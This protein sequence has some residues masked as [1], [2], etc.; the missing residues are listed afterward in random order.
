MGK[1]HSATGTKGN[2]AN[3]RPHPRGRSGWLIPETQTPRHIHRCAHSISGIAQKGKPDL[4]AKNAWQ[5]SLFRACRAS[6][7]FG[8]WPGDTA[9]HTAE[10]F[11]PG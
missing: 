5:I 7:G 4:P 10:T 6:G 2:S 9:R 8:N 11:T 3:A 1:A